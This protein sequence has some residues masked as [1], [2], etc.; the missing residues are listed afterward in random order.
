[1][2]DYA[3]GQIDVYDH[4]G[5]ARVH[6]KY[7]GGR[8]V[9]T[10][11]YDVEISRVRGIIEKNRPALKEILETARF[12]ARIYYDRQ[13]MRCLCGKIIIMQRDSPPNAILY[14]PLK[15]SHSTWRVSVPYC[16]SIHDIDTAHTISKCIK[17]CAKRM[18]DSHLIPFAL[19][20]ARKA[21]LWPSDITIS[22][23]L[24][25]LGQCSSQ[26]EIR[27]SYIL[28]LYPEE[29]AEYVVYHELAHLKQMD[30]GPR[31][32]AICDRLCGGREADL[33]LRVCDYRPP[34]LP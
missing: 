30:H 29:L 1:M 33:Y 24:R 21:D 22:K 16:R 8:L 12:R 7:T 27:L 25:E 17:V 14:G 5:V 10:I 34:I 11:P 3:L 31:F 23:G 18:A 28:M 6:F 2:R 32:H 9:M 13:E 15:H 4:R 26:G 20:V 19:K